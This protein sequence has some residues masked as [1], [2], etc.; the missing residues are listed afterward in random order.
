M[1]FSRWMLACILGGF[2]CGSPL[3]IEVGR[4]VPDAGMD[5]IDAYHQYYDAS[6]DVLPLLRATNPANGMLVEA[7][8]DC[9]GAYQDPPGASDVFPIGVDLVDEQ[10]GAPVSNNALVAI[11]P[12]GNFGYFD[13][14]YTDANGHIALLRVP[15]MSY[16]VHFEI[17]AIGQVHTTYRNFPLPPS[18]THLTLKSVSQ[19]TLDDIGTALGMPYGTGGAV[20]LVTVR[21]CQSRLVDGAVGSIVLGLGY[22]DNYHIFYYGGRA[23]PASHDQFWYTG[24]DGSYLAWNYQAGTD[25]TIEAAG[26]TIHQPQEITVAH[27][28]IN[29]IDGVGFTFVD[30][31]PLGP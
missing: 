13:N 24:P 19:P 11:Y 31:P 6:G 9:N 27:V 26:F 1:S 12:E 30:L 4:E 2:G 10:S 14:A 17:G 16:R 25:A 22:P 29:A 5:T 15:P 7:D 23:L 18:T 8:Y 28:V 20:V 21:D 3:P